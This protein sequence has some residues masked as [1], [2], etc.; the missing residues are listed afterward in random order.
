MNGHHNVPYHRLAARSIWFSP[1]FVRVMLDNMKRKSCLGRRF[2][3]GVGYLLLSVLILLVS[4][5]YGA[6]HAAEVAPSA[7]REVVADILT[8]GRYQTELPIKKPEPQPEPWCFWKLFGGECEG[9]GS[10]DVGIVVEVLLYGLAAVGVGLLL[11]ILYRL[12]VGRQ[13]RPSDQT[14][15]SDAAITLDAPAPEGAWSEFSIATAE[16]LAQAG[17]YNEAVHVILLCCL[18][19]AGQALKRSLTAREAIAHVDLDERGR[20]AFA[21]IVRTSERGHFGGY[22]LHD[23]DFRTCLQNYQQ[24]A[25]AAGSQA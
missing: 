6:A 5:N 15:E 4:D 8:G 24:L 22:S 18:Q 21:T 25:E 3:T 23:A 17:R 1:T 20:D 19:F 7:V 14:D 12:L 10:V 9:V 2:R 13:F 11:L 16:R